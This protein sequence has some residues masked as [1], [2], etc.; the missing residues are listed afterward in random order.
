M[1]TLNNEKIKSA[2]ICPIC[3]SGVELSYEGSGRMFCGGIRTHSY[4]F[5]SGGY[6]N[7]SSPGQSGG[8]D[9]K[10]A[11]AARTRFLELGYYSPI[12]E[13]LAELLNAY[14]QLKNEP[15]LIDAGCGE[16]YYSTYLAEQGA[17]VAGFDLSKFAIDSAAKRAKR[18]GLQNAFFGVASVYSIPIADGSADAVVNIFAP[19]VEKEYSRLLKD[20]GV[21]IVA[22]AAEDHLV[23]LK[24]IIYDDVRKNDCRADMPVELE[25]ISTHRLKYTV[26]IE[27]RENIKS[28]FAMTPYYWRTSQSDVNK[29]DSVDRLSTEIDVLFEIYHKR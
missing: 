22:G 29:L 9:S 27:G 17:A 18:A 26:E 7:L 14:T 23:G 3:K 2:L 20:G 21:L 12:K 5:A 24:S 1:L 28:L 4:D 19:C 11:V 13:K 15:L 8:G 6:V 10:Q 25:R 16:G